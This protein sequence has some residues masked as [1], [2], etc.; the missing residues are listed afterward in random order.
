MHI[1]SSHGA[2]GRRVALVAALGCLIGVFEMAAAV[3]GGA[4]ESGTF[5][6]IDM[7]L[8]YGGD[9]PEDPSV[10]VEYLAPGGSASVWSSSLGAKIVVADW[11]VDGLELCLSYP[12]E[13]IGPSQ[14][15]TLVMCE[16]T[17]IIAE[18]VL[19]SARGDIF[20]LSE[21]SEAPVEL[22]PEVRSLEDVTKL[23][24]GR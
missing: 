10:Q 16:Q 1:P 24:D 22:T 13:T 3:A 23:L 7:T 20:R 4:S 14:T 12:P 9:G 6:F 15:N 8:L 11:S 19:D 2:R 18:R 5:D 21:R 17:A